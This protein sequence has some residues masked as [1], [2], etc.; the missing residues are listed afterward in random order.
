MT[1]HY[2]TYFPIM[3]E[4]YTKKSLLARG[5]LIYPVK[6]ERRTP[7]KVFVKGRGG[8]D[9]LGGQLRSRP[10]FLGSW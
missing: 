10:P 7:K 9:P 8:E 6:K 2:H 1:L 5:R 3:S 4:L